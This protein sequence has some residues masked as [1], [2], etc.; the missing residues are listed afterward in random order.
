MQCKGV[1]RKVSKIA[2]P[3]RTKF[4][5]SKGSQLGT[6]AAQLNVKR[7]VKMLF[8]HI[9][10]DGAWPRKQVNKTTF[11][12]CLFRNALSDVHHLLMF[13]LRGLIC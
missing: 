7:F 12:T 10:L 11:P 6:F 5:N 1:L 8:R 13:N 2:F 4:V 3:D 9:A